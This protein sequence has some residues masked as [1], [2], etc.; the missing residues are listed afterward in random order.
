MAHGTA[1]HKCRFHPQQH[2]QLET[3]DIMRTNIA[4][5]GC[6]NGHE[7]EIRYSHT[8]GRPLDADLSARIYKA[9][10]TDSCGLIEAHDPSVRFVDYRPLTTPHHLNFGDGSTPCTVMLSSQVAHGATALMSMSVAAAQEFAADM[11]RSNLWHVTVTPDT[12]E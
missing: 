4:I 1:Y 11:I 8:T 9:S 12:G 5:I 2:H 10:I 6:H 3:R 7:V